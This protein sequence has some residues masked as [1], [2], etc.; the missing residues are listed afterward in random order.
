VIDTKQ[1]EVINASIGSRLLVLAPPGTGKTHTLIERV[2]HLIRS[3][4]VPT[5]SAIVIL[6]FTRAAVAEIVARI[7]SAVQEGAADNLRYVTVRTFDSFATRMLMRD[8]AQGRLPQGYEDRIRNFAFRLKANQL[9]EAGREIDQIRCLIVDEVQDLVGARAQMVLE[10]M[11]RVVGQG[12]GVVLLGDPAQAIY[13]WQSENGQEMRSHQFLA[14][15]RRLLGP[16][17]RE[18][19]LEQDYRSTDDEVR[20]FAREARHAMGKDGTTADGIHLGRLLRLLGSPLDFQAAATHTGSGRVA[21]LTRQNVQAFQFSEW[22]RQQNVPCSLFRGSTGHYSAGWLA[23][24]THGFR[25][26]RMSL[27]VAESRWHALVQDGP[28]RSFTEAMAQLRAAGVAT[29]S[30]IDLVALSRRVLQRHP[31]L[32]AATA[33][34]GRL[35]VSTIHKA[36]GLQF[37]A[38]YLLEPDRWEGDAEE[39]RVVYVAATRARSRLRVLRNDKKTLGKS[40]KPVGRIKL[41]H[42]HTY[43]RDTGVN[44]LFLDGVEEIDCDSL[45]DFGT[46]TGDSRGL[47]QERHD[48]LWRGVADMVADMSAVSTPDGFLLMIPSDADAGNSVPVCLFGS[49]L[50]QDLAQLRRSVKLRAIGLSGI[51]VIGLAS[52]AFPPDDQEATDM[53]GTARL[54]LAPVLHGWA[55]VV[56][57]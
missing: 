13:D 31:R 1:A 37:D 52:V 27:S 48:A 55:T 30:F 56:T 21:V 6:S 51:R 43:N 54:A 33:N 2:A 41:E 18:V 5:A 39:V 44:Q 40:Y 24:L 47:M 16:S 22:C 46:T 49:A 57:N 4:A 35:V 8:V 12:G 23:R 36:K 9:P 20:R 53:L 34:A 3:G 45:L 42:L 15:A 7:G 32:A 26:D 29:D 28:G 50:E 19:V 38:V 11:A 17:M 25:M 14:S 10:L